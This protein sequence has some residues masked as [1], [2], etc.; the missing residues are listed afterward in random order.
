MTVYPTRHYLIVVIVSCIVSCIVGVLSASAQDVA[1]TAEPTAAPQE[2]SECHLDVVAQ[3]QTGTHITAFHTADFQAGWT[4]AERGGMC[5]SCHTTGYTPY[6][7]T[8][9]HEGVTCTACHG[10]TPASHPAEPVAADPGVQVCAD[11]HPSTVREWEQSEHWANDLTC[12]T[13]HEPH[14]QRLRFETAD[15]L[16]RDCHT[17]PLTDYA[18]TSHPDNACVDCHWY[19][20]FDSSVHLQTGAIL[21]S[22]HDGRAELRTCLDCHRESETLVSF[23]QTTSTTRLAIAAPVTAPPP[24]TVQAVHPLLAGLLVG[25]GFGC[26]AVFVLHALRPARKRDTT[27]AVEK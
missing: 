16:C 3:W 24:P 26:A 2:C 17:E 27:A 20:G 5:L 4:A 23:V 8:Y 14:T 7:E 1:V 6:N 19:G 9:R 21:S 18:H 22:G 11:C 13:C 12:A 10:L 25:L 15:A